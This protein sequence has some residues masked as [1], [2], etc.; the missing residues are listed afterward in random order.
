[1]ERKKLVML[2]SLLM[3]FMLLGS[4]STVVAF[5]LD[6]GD[7]GTEYTKADVT[8]KFQKLRCVED[9]DWNSGADVW[10]RIDGPIDYYTYY[11]QL[12]MIYGFE[13]VIDGATGY[14]E[15]ELKSSLWNGYGAGG[16][17][18]VTYQNVNLNNDFVLRLRV[19]D[20]DGWFNDELVECRL[21]V[22]SHASVESSRSYNNIFAHCA[23]QYDAYF[24]TNY[25]TYGYEDSYINY[26][27]IDGAGFWFGGIS[28]DYR[29][30]TSNGLYID[31]CLNYH[32]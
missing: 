23:G 6:P 13:G 17:F 8:V 4:L 10:M 26:E 29:S 15:T 32:L 27:W 16:Y 24:G 12:D 25:Y 22:K 3:V 31:V 9:T 1:M 11:A 19:R 18:E 21:T 5:D 20:D 28:D 14:P 7:G 30:Y 2:G